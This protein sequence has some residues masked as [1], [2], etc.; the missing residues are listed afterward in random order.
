MKRIVVLIS[1]VG[2]G[3]NLQA[4]IDAQKSKK[5]NIKIAAVISDT[6]KAFGI[7]RAKNNR[8]PVKICK[9]KKDLLSILEK[10]NP[11]YIAL[12]GWKQIIEPNVLKNFK[13]RILNLHPG[14]LPDSINSY[15]I[16]PDGTKALANRGL[17]AEKA[18]LNFLQKKAT[19]AGS[20]IHFL[21]EEFD[22]G[23]VLERAF[24]KISKNDT[25]ETLYP[26]LKRKEHEI[27]VKALK[28]LT[29]VPKDA[30]VLVIDGGGRGSV[31]VEKY[32]Q[33]PNVARILAVPGN[34]LMQINSKKP[35]SVFSDIKTTDVENI[36]KIAKKFKVD[37]VDVA[38]DDAVAVGVTDKLEN[39]GFKVFGPTRAS[40]QI[41]WDKAWSRQFMTNFKIPSP[42]FKI[43]TSEKEGID[44]IKT[45]KD[46]EWFIKASGLAAG[47]GALYAKDKKQAVEKIRQMKNFGPAGETFLIEECIKGE[48]FS[49]FALADGN[50]FILLGE[51]Q[52]HKTVYNADAGPNTGGM[53]CSSP[54]LAITPKLKK[55]IE[56][57][58]RKTLNGLVKAERPYRGILYLGG[59]IDQKGKVYVIEFNARWGDPEA[60]VI[61]PSIKNDF[62]E[63]ALK[64]ISKNLSQ[65]KLEKDNLYRITVAATAKGYPQ[66]YKD[67]VGKQVFGIEL[68]RKIPTVTLY[69]AAVKKRGKKYISAGG[70]LFY[71]TA[72][73]KNIAQ[74]RQ[75]AYNALSL[76]Y[77][78]GNNLHYRTDIGYRDIER[79]YGKN[80]T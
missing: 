15:V 26:K 41:E 63:L 67:V 55:Q 3:S 17:L 56:E 1:D 57:I 69:P 44:F 24:V 19:Y 4:I 11:D 64:V 49:A 5:L 60:Q 18:V 47:K 9:E 37:L 43:A 27:Y 30:T 35:V 70:R 40:G 6:A 61:V 66:E 10:I 8:I 7:Q 74:A 48:E 50:N 31:L 79:I 36:I 23:P 42:K 22:F 12:A 14:L 28:K 52:D 80:H 45:Q 53:G 29:E 72:K 2:T 62:F 16:A 46:G 38:Q 13:D 58:F 34:D 39:E 33:S 54:P 77:I 71:I 73:G 76:A 59:M 65:I 78:E 20:S 51:A 21:T 75:K 68:V 32:S 25:V